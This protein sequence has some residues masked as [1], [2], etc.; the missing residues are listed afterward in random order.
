MRWETVATLLML[1][2]AVTILVSA[3]AG[4]VGDVRSLGC[5]ARWARQEDSPC[6]R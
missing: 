6:G 5:P 3:V 1:G 2:V 4:L